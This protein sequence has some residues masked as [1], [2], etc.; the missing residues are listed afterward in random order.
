VTAAANTQIES[1][2]SRLVVRRR[3]EAH[4]DRSAWAVRA[5]RAWLG[6]EVEPAPPGMHR[7]QADLR[8]RVSERPFLATFG[9]AA[10]V[11]FGPIQPLDGG[12][13]VE[14]SWRA[15]TLAPL[16]PVF[17]GSIVAREGEL[18]LSGWY[19]P[20]GGSIGRIADRAL[21]HLAATGTAQ[22]LLRE[23]EAAASASAG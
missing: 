17:S 19:A 22:W 14:V 9:K 10:Y 11:D 4:P 20:P 2:L 3:S 21:L 12:W 5:A 18:T 15:A 6:P 7:H 13:Q 16:F 1:G 8:L 23:L